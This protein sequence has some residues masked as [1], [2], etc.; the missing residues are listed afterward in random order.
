[1]MDSK[2]FEQGLQDFNLGKDAA[3]L[4][5]TQESL[6]P[7]EDKEAKPMQ[8]AGIGRSVLK[9][10]FGEEMGN[11]IGRSSHDLVKNIPSKPIGK[12]LVGEEVEKVLSRFA[13]DKAGNTL[14]GADIPKPS[15]V[16]RGSESISDMERLVN[17][18]ADIDVQNTPRQFKE[19][20]GDLST[21]EDVMEEMRPIFEGTNQ[22]ALLTDKQVYGLSRIVK[23]AQDDLITLG[24]KIKDGDRTPE[25]LIQYD[26]ASKVFETMYYYAR[27][28][29][30]ETARALNAQKMVAGVLDSDDLRL[31]GSILSGEQGSTNA[32]NIVKH[33][34]MLVDKAGKTN[35]GK[36]AIFAARHLGNGTRVAVEFWKNNI[37]SNIG[38]HAVN[39]STVAMVIPWAN[40]VVRPLAA[41]IGVIRTKGAKGVDRVYL[42]ESAAALASSYAG[43]RGSLRLFWE[44]L[45]TG[46]SS[47]MK[48]VDKVEQ[49]TAMEEMIGHNK[50]GRLAAKASSGSFR[51]LRAEDDAMRGLAFVQELYAIGA[52]KGKMA[53]LEGDAYNKHMN[54]FLNDPPYE[55][56][57]QASVFAAQQ[58]FTDT[59]SNSIIGKMTPS[60]RSLVGNIP[61][62]QFVVPFVNTPMRLLQYGIESSALAPASF[63]LWH[64]MAKGGAAADV[65]TAKMIS[66]IGLST[67]LWMAY[68][69]GYVTGPG[70][71]D[72]KMAQMMKREGWQPN[73]WVD[74]E[75]GQMSGMERMDPF[76][77]SMNLTLGLFEKSRYART[78][79]KA[80]EYWAKATLSMAQNMMDPTWMA[81]THDAV[82]AFESEGMMKK[83]F[84]NIGS[85]FV[86]YSG[87]LSSI[88]K[89]KDES[90]PR[91]GAD[92]FVSDLSNM[93]KQRI[94]G[95]LPWLSEYVRPGRY[96]DGA[97]IMPE[98]EGFAWAMSPIKQGLLGK[99]DRSN[100]ELL[101]NGVVPTEPSSVL[102]LGPV[103]FSLLQL[104]ETEQ[105]YDLYIQTV[106][107]ARHDVLIDVISNSRYAELS[108]GP[109]GEKFSVLTRSIAAANNKG[110]VDFLEKL[111]R[112]LGRDKELHTKLAEQLAADPVQFIRAM[113]EDAN[114]EVK[115]QVK[116]RPT[117]QPYEIPRME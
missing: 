26:N 13:K 19:I 45:R 114:T 107:Q 48:N 22:A 55:S 27:G 25:L 9:G 47:F 44:A 4:T 102:S 89:I 110:K 14:A 53:G 29:A 64:E 62:L 106:G 73:S 90:S 38:T 60:I 108:K 95:N 76:T 16:L 67:T 40:Y 99:G 49:G 7:V 24:H 93:T 11:V 103:K 79:A 54:E 3:A 59:E 34:E 87:L 17:Q 83:Y 5:V 21:V 23:T 1:M 104:D 100:R 15:D 66:G 98:N 65:A 91:V 2:E 92:E 32:K 57:E 51:F 82:R 36:A 71:D 96:W 113:I 74:P 41:G 37:L 94:M 97:V 18:V 86:P 109:N 85:G 69:N 28:N 61:L 39:V 68:D 50:V 35:V 52:R 6:K 88:K 58:T 31:Y 84:A 33:A 70:P 115:G 12:D 42:A 80:K 30:K 10:L 20:E 78:E 111:E 105:I 75:T 112:K 43:V 46:E 116:Y 117:R 63:R 81:S 101:E 56:Y 77:I 8:V 72:Y